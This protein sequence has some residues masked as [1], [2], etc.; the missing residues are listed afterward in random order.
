MNPDGLNMYLTYMFKPVWWVVM[1]RAFLTSMDKRV[2]QTNRTKSIVPLLLILAILSPLHARAHCDTMDGPVVTD[3]R[4]ALDR[5]DLTPVLKWIRADQEAELRQV[6]AQV[7]AVRAMG[8]KVRQ[9]ADRL[10]YETAV[11]LHR[12]A[13][14]EPYTGLKPPEADSHP[15]VTA[16]ERAIERGEVDSLIQDVSR[17]LSHAIR[18][19]FERVLELRSRAERGV[20]EGRAYV[21]AYVDYLHF[22]RLLYDLGS[23][24]HA[25]DR[26]SG[27][28]HTNGFSAKPLPVPDP[29]AD[30][31]AGATVSNPAAQP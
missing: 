18:Q 21:A 31:H 13:E 29:P 22:V 12:M 15:G 11:R 30:R 2:Q 28:A 17:H 1:Q 23:P 27:P 6:F 5:Q 3:A 24:R 8:E 14:G 19:R 26:I 10:F 25:P 7:V 16:A 4:L 20:Q 9:V